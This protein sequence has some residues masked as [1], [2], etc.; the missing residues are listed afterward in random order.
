MKK[1]LLTIL[2]TLMITSSFAQK[3]DAAYYRSKGYQVFNNIGVAVKAP[4]LL[5]DV[6]R[7]AS[8]DFYLNYGGFEEKNKPTMAAYQFI[9]SALPAGYKDYSESQLQKM[10]GEK[11]KSIM[12]SF[13]NVKKVYF[14]EEGCIGYV[15][16]T[17]SD[18]YNQRGLMFYRKGYTYAITVISN[19][20]LEQ[21][22]NK[23]T[24]GVKFF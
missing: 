16:D 6:S 4:V 24:N 15:G 19:Y 17:K 18:G 20:Q 11:L 9:V 1:A 8:G 22:F 7:Q 2:V 3:K 23:F 14:G 12:K 21:R 5:E 13:T 10:V